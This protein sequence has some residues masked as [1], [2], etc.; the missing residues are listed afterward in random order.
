MRTEEYLESMREKQSEVRETRVSRV[1][2]HRA[3]DSRGYELELDSSATMT[4]TL[5][6][7][8]GELAQLYRQIGDALSSRE[9]RL[10]VMRGALLD[11]ILDRKTGAGS[12]LSRAED[13]DDGV[14]VSVEGSLD[15]QQLAG[16]AL[17]T[18]ESFS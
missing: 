1:T 2:G 9:S 8:R 16:V 11:S 10:Q 13:D 18:V 15:V 14:W 12:D 6:L 7:S 3:I 5:D 4:T 17:D